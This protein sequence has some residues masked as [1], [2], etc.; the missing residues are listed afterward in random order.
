[1][2]SYSSNGGLFLRRLTVIFTICTLLAVALNSHRKAM[3]IEN[4]KNLDNLN[5][6]SVIQYGFRSRRSTG[7]DSNPVT[8][9]KRVHGGGGKYWYS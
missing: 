5:I 1:M 7:D 2:S 3:I 8:Y 6:I 4:I 9:T